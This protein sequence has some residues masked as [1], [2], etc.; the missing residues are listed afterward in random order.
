MMQE[1]YCTSGQVI[2][3]R[4]ARIDRSDRDHFAYNFAASLIAKGY[5]T[6]AIIKYNGSRR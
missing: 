4:G 1:S 2:D 3:W 6:R 5:V